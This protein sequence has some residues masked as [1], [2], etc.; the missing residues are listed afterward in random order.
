MRLPLVVGLDRAGLVGGDGPTHQGIYDIALL[1]PVPGIVMMAPKDEN[2]LQHMVFTAS[3]LDRPAFIRYPKEPG[4]GVPLD[5]EFSQLPLGKSEVLRRGGR[6]LILAVGP[7]AYRALDAAGELAARDGI[8][9]TVVNVR[10]IKPLDRELIFSLAAGIAKIATVEDGTV[11]G[12][13]AGIVRAEFLDSGDRTHEFLALG[14]GED[15]FF[16]ASR[17]E[18][19]AQCGLD[20]DGML[21]PPARLR[22]GSVVVR[23]APGHVRAVASGRG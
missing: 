19:L 13:F 21:P 20:A 1:Q 6:L 16:P 14:V 12:G 10:F 7:L 9:A 22:Q 3:R 4:R 8:E 17:E 2:E 15:N 11:R 5:K 18:L 23:P